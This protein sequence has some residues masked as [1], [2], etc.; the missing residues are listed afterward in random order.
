MGEKEKRRIKIGT[1]ECT[2]EILISQMISERASI[3]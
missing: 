2:I 1:K 3:M